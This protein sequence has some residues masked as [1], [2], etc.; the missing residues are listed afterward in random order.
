MLVSASKQM[1]SR[2]GLVQSSCWLYNH[3]EKAKHC[4]ITQARV[5]PG[6]LC[7]QGKLACL[8]GGVD[9]GLPVDDG[10]DALRG[11]LALG[12]ICSKKQTSYQWLQAKQSGRLRAAWVERECSAGGMPQ[13][14]AN[15]GQALQAPVAGGR[16]VPG[17]NIW[18]CAAPMAARKME[19]KTCRGGGPTVCAWG[20]GKKGGGDEGA[21]V[22][23]CAPWA[24][25]RA[26]RHAPGAARAHLIP[27]GTGRPRTPSGGSAPAMYP[28]CTSNPHCRSRCLLAA[29]PHLEHLIKGVLSAGHQPAGVPEGQGID[30]KGDELGGCKAQACRQLQAARGSRLRKE[31]CLDRQALLTAPFPTSEKQAGVER[32]G[33]AWQSEARRL[34]SI[35]HRSLPPCLPRWI[36]AAPRVWASPAWRHTAPIPAGRAG[37]LFASWLRL[38]CP[39]CCT[40]LQRPAA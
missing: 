14:N 6:P 23:T 35:Q 28:R 18:A 29:G 20:G 9:L 39:T 37:Q 17:K 21:H 24:P 32:A 2:Q 10:E 33:E 1:A 31:T 7:Q 12:H 8:A 16:L 11:R 13:A 25:A 19:K 4:P 38:H 27:A 22:C 36:G 5:K 30:A 40:D 26:R 15:Q 3:L 34:G